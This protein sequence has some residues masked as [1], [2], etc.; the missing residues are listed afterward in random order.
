METLLYP[1]YKLLA[2]IFNAT[3]YWL[4]ICGLKELIKNP[5]MVQWYYLFLLISFVFINPRWNNDFKM[6]K[7]KFQANEWYENNFV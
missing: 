5:E 1:F 2:F 6:V 3:E 4:I 7:K